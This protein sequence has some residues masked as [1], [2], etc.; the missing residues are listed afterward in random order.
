MICY[1]WESLKLSIKVEIEQQDWESIDYEEMVQKTVNTEVKAG[2]R[3]S[4]MVR[5]S[6]IHYPRGHRLSNSTAGKV[7]TQETKDAHPKEPKVKEVRPT[8]F[9]AGANK[10]SEQARKK[11]KKKR[12][13]EKRDKDQTPASTGNAMEVQQKRK[14]KNQD[15]D[16]SKVTS[17]NCNKKGH[18]ISTGIK[19]LKN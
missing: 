3:S 9:W 14:K 1:F 2:L 4:T 19:P 18:Y 5:D 15:W 13:Q 16:V 17:F 7:Q 10:L 11:K 12:H 6:D 8:P